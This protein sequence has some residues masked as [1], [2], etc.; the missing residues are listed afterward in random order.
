M[1]FLHS[2]LTLRLDA[3]KLY[4]AAAHSVSAETLSTSLSLEAMRTQAATRQYGET[5]SDSEEERNRSIRET[6][7]GN[8]P[9][10]QPHSQHTWRGEERGGGGERREEG[11]GEGRRGGE[12]RGDME[13]R[14]EERRGE[15]RRG[16]ERRGGE[17]RI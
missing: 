10:S 3:W 1:Y 6:A 17:E 2:I 8:T 4:S 16:E 9:S 13:R 14:G 15:E 7:R 5:G 12:E 11:E